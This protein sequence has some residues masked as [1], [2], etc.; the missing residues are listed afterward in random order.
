MPTSEQLKAL[1]NLKEQNMVPKAKV[2]R[3]SRHYSRNV[4]MDPP[5]YIY[6]INS[7]YGYMKDKYHNKINIEYCLLEFNGDILNYKNFLSDVI[8]NRDPSKANPSSIRGYKY[9][10]ISFLFIYLN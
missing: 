1:G 7:F 9:I 10:Y 3:Y 4:N 2:S 8:G 6:I 5:S